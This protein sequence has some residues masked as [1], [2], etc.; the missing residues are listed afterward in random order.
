MTKTQRSLH[1]H[2]PA[3]LD[4]LL[5]RKRNK[6]KAYRALK[7]NDYEQLFASHCPRMIKYKPS[8]ELAR[9]VVKHVTRGLPRLKAKHF[10]WKVYNRLHMLPLRIGVERPNCCYM[11]NPKID[12]YEMGIRDKYIRNELARYL[13]KK[14]YTHRAGINKIRSQKYKFRTLFIQTH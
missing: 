3:N 9:A 7:N 2:N 12:W 11:K 6:P 10:A 13:L 14:R 1:K 8:K 4:I 5:S